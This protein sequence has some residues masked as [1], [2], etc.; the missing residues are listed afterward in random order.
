M[1]L[2]PRTSSLMAISAT[3]MAARV[4]LFS[5]RLVTA[6]I[7]S[8][9]LGGR[10]MTSTVKVLL[11]A[12]LVK[13]TTGMVWRTR[14]VSWP[15]SKPITSVCTTERDHVPSAATN[16]VLPD[17]SSVPLSNSRLIVD[18]G[19]PRPLI[20]KP[21][22]RS[23]AEIES[24]PVIASMLGTGASSIRKSWATAGLVR[25]NCVMT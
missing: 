17:W 9:A 25:P 20:T 1:M 6:S 10:L 15:R 11:T 13:P 14:T 8:T 19:M 7:R 24:S 5:A 2:L 23:L 21:L 22:R 16:A 4:E 12:P 3:L 18:P